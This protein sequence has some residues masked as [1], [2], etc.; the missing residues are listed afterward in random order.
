MHC[1][2]IEPQ[3]FSRWERARRC[4]V[5][6]NRF[7][8]NMLA[9]IR[10]HE[11][12]I[13]V[14]RKEEYITAEN[15]LFKQAQVSSFPEDY[16]LLASGKSVQRGSS[17]QK[18]SP[19]LDNN[20]V[21][22]CK[23]PILLPGNHPLTKLILKYY[24]ERYLHIHHETALSSILQGFEVPKLRVEMGKVK[25]SCQT[26]KNIKAKPQIPEMCG[27]PSSR[28]STFT[29][30]FTFIGVDYFGPLT[31]V[32]G[33]QHLKRWGVIFTCL[34]VRAVHLEISHSLTTA[35]WR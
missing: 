4:Q 29:R 14:V 2:Y 20:G 32:S 6:V 23:R 17:I 3:N 13:G 25:A 9:K 26:C 18:Y 15:Y 28:L 33:R 30:P 1:T 8:H 19:Y 31:I 12:R 35:Y 11:K 16:E 27:L 10:L 22:R 21:I 5:F 24:H 34:S 7:V